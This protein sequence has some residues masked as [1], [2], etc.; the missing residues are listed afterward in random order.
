M[1]YKFHVSPFMGANLWGGECIT[2]NVF[3]P[4]ISELDDFFLVFTKFWARNWSSGISDDQFLG[5][6]TS[7][8]FTVV[9]KN[10]GNRAGMSN[11]LNHPP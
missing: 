10:L 2:P 7:L 3:M 1:G 8:H 4:H 5:V 6:F 9:G 11:L